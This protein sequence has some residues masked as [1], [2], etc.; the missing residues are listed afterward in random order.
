MEVQPINAGVS[1]LPAAP[2][3]NLTAYQSTRVKPVQFWNAPAASSVTVAGITILTPAAVVPRFVQP[4]NAVPLMYLTFA[5]FASV[6]AVTPLNAE[7]PIVSK[8]LGQVNFAIF[9]APNANVPMVFKPSLRLTSAKA[10]QPRNTLAPMVF[11]VAGKVTL[12]IVRLV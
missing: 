11:K 1:L 7:T 10:V 6:R 8:V 12:V 9:V 5:R 3:D 4:A 2:D